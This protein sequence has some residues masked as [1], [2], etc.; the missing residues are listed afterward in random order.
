MV[1]SLPPSYYPSLH[2]TPHRFYSLLSSPV[3]LSLMSLPPYLHVSIRLNQDTE[4]HLPLSLYVQS[5][6]FDTGFSI[7]FTTLWIRD[8]Q[9]QFYHVLPFQKESPYFTLQSLAAFTSNKQHLIPLLIFASFFLQLKQCHL[10]TVLCIF[11]FHLVLSIFNFIPLPRQCSIYF[12][13]YICIYVIDFT[14]FSNLPPTPYNLNPF[15]TAS[16]CI[17]TTYTYKFLPFS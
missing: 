17:N 6:C 15:Q 14:L 5:T 3:K 13:T 16:R 12:N 10:Q 9:I 2:H 11:R 7:V 8:F 1:P 4:I